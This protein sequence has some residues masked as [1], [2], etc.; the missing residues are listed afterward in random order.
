[1]TILAYVPD[2]MDR[3]RFGGV[4]VAFVS[5]PAA[6]EEAGEDDVVV[7]DLSRPAVLA[8]LPRVRAR[9]TIGF[10]SHVDRERLDAARAAG[11]DEVMVRSEFFRRVKEVLA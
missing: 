8:V 5:D 9:R 7:V 10:G 2:L 6:L 3:S 1:V 11:C 4:T